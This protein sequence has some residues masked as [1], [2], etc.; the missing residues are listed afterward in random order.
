MSYFN[1]R[2]FPQFDALSSSTTSCAVSRYS[3]AKNCRENN[4]FQTRK[5]N[6]FSRERNFFVAINNYFSRKNNLLVAKI[7]F[8][9]RENNYFVAKNNFFVAKFFCREFFFSRIFFF[10]RENNCGTREHQLKDPR[11]KSRN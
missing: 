10:F 4:F 9:S 1:N 7:T 3:G 6:F 11:N 2:S 5:F 8:F